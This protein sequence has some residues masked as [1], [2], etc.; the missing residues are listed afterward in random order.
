MMHGLTLPALLSDPGTAICQ[1]GAPFATWTIFR[2][3]CLYNAA[4][5]CIADCALV[6]RKAPLPASSTRYIHTATCGNRLDYY[7]T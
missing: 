7:Q 2:K 3:L 1:G 6:V 5:A 4:N